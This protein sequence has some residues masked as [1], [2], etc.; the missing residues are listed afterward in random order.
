MDIGDRLNWFRTTSNGG[1]HIS[2][3]FIILVHLMKCYLGRKL[4]SDEMQ[5]IRG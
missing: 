2:E 1:L 3:L 5:L 4:V